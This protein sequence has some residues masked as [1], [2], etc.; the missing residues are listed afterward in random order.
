M[1]SN[2]PAFPGRIDLVR[3]EEQEMNANSKAVEADKKMFAPT[4]EFNYF[5][6][7]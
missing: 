4:S 5:L 6:I 3:T 7:E 2:Q 1:K